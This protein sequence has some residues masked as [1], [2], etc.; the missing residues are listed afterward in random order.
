MALEHPQPGINVPKGAN[1]LVY[2]ML[3][4]LWKTTGYVSPFTTTTSQPTYYSR[5]ISD[6]CFQATER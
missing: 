3:M 1:P 4:S 5:F 6:E 2:C